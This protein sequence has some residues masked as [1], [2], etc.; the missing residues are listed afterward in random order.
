VL[1][2]PNIVDKKKIRYKAIN[3]NPKI[4]SAKAKITCTTNYHKP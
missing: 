3:F 4:V 2:L 1:T